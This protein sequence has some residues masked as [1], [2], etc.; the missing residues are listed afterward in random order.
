MEA[1][2]FKR[3]TVSESTK[4]VS[5]KAKGDDAETRALRHLQAHGLTLVQRN[6]RV[7]RGPHARGGEVD[8]IVRDADGT[9]VFVEV[10][11]RETSDHGAAA[12]TVTLRKRQRIVWAARHYLMRLPSEPPCRFDVVALE[13]PTLH[14]LQGAFAAGS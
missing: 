5:T 2:D 6:Y 8:L 9:L 11:S 1:S 14:W 4:A 13:G 10:R 7:A 3:K 12:E